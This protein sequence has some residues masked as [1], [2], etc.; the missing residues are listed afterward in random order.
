MWSAFPFLSLRSAIFFQNTEHLIKINF[1]RTSHS[2]ALHIFIINI[3]TEN[4]FVFILF[5]NMK[6]NKMFK[7]TKQVVSIY[8]KL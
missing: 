8:S 6:A 7:C 5:N 3:Y 1:T 2:T 4:E